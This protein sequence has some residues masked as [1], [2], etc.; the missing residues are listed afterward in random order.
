MT[1]AAALRIRIVSALRHR[2]TTLATRCTLLAAFSLRS[3]AACSV[4]MQ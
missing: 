4:D 3:A 1:V 2:M